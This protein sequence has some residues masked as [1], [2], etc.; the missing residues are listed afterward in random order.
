MRNEKVDFDLS[1]LS[2]KNLVDVYHEIANFI[3][4]LE[5]NKI[6]LEEENDG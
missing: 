1:E 2:L 3:Q 6:E 4:F 5:D